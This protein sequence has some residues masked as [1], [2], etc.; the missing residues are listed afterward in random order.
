MDQASVLR[1]MKKR[2]SVGAALPAFDMQK[3]SLSKQRVRVVA[4]TSGKGGVG[5][6]NISVNLAYFLSKLNKKVLMLDADVGLANIDVILGLTPQY[7][8][9]HVLRGEK[10]IQEIM[11]EGPGGMLILPAASGIQE[12]T[13]LS[14]GNRLT[15][16]DEIKTLQDR[17]DFMLIDTGAGIAS[18]VMYF[19]MVAQEIIVITTPEPTAIT[20]AYAL[21]KVLHQRHAKEHFRLLVNMV[22]TESEAKEVFSRLNQATNHFLNI[23][24]EYLGHVIY[25]KR[26]SE[27]IRKQQPFVTLF[28]DVPAAKCLRNLAEKI[29]KERFTEV[30]GTPGFFWDAI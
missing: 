30:T 15:L 2:E 18:H 21:I 27:S 5:K 22:K 20:D 26:V 12:M 16:I 14:Q 10:S 28:P 4:V 29:A 24:V 1:E 7:N 19:N 6:T 9:Y 11:V 3:Q 8:L 13:N 17:V 23:S 25:D